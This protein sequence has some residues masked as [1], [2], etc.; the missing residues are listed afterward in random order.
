MV[1]ESRGLK[2]EAA[3]GRI[4]VVSADGTPLM[5]CKPAKALKLLRCCKAFLGAR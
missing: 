4:N 2:D 1:G 5:P 3:I